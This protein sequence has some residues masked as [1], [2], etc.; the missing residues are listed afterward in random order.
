[1]K[2]SLLNI[3]LLSHLPLLHAALFIFH[4]KAVL[5]AVLQAVLRCTGGCVTQVKELYEREVGIVVTAQLS[6]FEA[7]T[8][9][10]R[11]VGAKAR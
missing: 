7:I 10:I 2:M 9:E 5:Q 6:T 11:E 1:M 8:T 4:I 3:H